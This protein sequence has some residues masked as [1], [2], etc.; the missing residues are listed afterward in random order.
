MSDL[1]VDF[2][3]VDVGP[4]PD[5][6][7]GAD[8]ESAL[9]GGLGGGAG[10][11]NTLFLS[12]ILPVSDARTVDDEDEDD[13]RTVERA[14]RSRLPGL[15]MAHFRDTGCLLRVGL[16]WTDPGK[17]LEDAETRMPGE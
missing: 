15:S 4:S 1:E 10:M 2:G 12:F 13:S 8:F 5:A 9:E 14:S 11:G 6:G 7:V 3:V 17:S 16:C